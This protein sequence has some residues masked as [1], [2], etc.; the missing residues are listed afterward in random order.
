MKHRNSGNSRDTLSTKLRQLL[1]F[2]GV[3]VDEAIHVAD[4]E[5]LD[6]VARCELPLRTQAASILETRNE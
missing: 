4:A 3:D 2:R 5:T 1:P 6:V